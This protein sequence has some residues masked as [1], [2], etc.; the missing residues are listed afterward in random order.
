MIFESEFVLYLITKSFPDFAVVGTS[1][2]MESLRADLL[3]ANGM[4]A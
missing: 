1:K 2:S 4:A 3:M